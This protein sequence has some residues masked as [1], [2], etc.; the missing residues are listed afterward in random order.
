LKNSKLKSNKKS[1]LIGSW[2][3]SLSLAKRSIL[4]YFKKSPFCISFEI[5]HS[6]NASCKHCHLGGPVREV[7]ASPQRYGE[8]CREVKPVVAQVSGGEPL[9]RKDLEEIVKAFKVPKRAPYIVVTTNAAL[10]TKEKYFKLREAGVDEFSISLDYPDDRHDDFRGIPGLFNR[11]KTL[12]QELDQEKNKAITFICVVQ[13]DNFRELIRMAELARDWRASVN[14]S[15]YTWLRTNDKSYMLAKE[16]LAEFRD[17]IRQLLKFKRKHNTVFTSDY[18]LRNMA[19][20]FENGYHPRCRTGEKFINVNP[21][22]TF[23][24]CGLLIKDFKTAD[25]LRKNFALDNSCVF[26]YT[27]IRAN[28]EKPARY[29]IKDSLKSI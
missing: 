14:F 19:G 12:A 13:R 5:T 6:C 29:L 8:I 18:A 24:P 4:N 10:L 17:I 2:P 23:S 28:T 26:C 25:D 21:D 1:I 15:A 20:Y 9:L 22:G 11:I 16:D 7:R 27:S 3:R